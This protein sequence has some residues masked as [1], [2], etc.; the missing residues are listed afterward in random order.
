LEKLIQR[1]NVPASDHAGRVYGENQR[2]PIQLR[3]CNVLKNWVE[4]H[5]SDFTDATLQRLNQFIDSTLSRENVNLAKTLRNAISKQTDGA[6]KLQTNPSPMPE[7]K[8]PKTVFSHSLSVAEIDDEEVARQMT[9]VDYE[10][11]AAIQPIELLNCAWDKPNLKHRSPN[12]LA[13]LERQ[14]K[15]SAWVSR[16]LVEPA[17]IADRVKM[18]NMWL[19]IAARLRALNNYHGLYA[20]AQGFQHT[21]VRWLTFTRLELASAEKDIYMSLEKTF[22]FND[23]LYAEYKRKLGEV[24]SSMPCI[25]WLGLPLR[26][27][28]DLEDKHPDLIPTVAGQKLINFAK[29]KLIYN[30]IL[31]LQQHQQRQ[32]HLMGIAQIQKVV[33]SCKPND[34]KDLNALA[35]KWEPSGAQRGD[36]S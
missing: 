17:K 9:L 28:K 34:P 35:N 30:L 27:L 15:V 23:A 29:R 20:V 10:L 7:P 8:V 14:A 33:Q 22:P 12:V 3:V 18:F 6:P 25:P 1:Y 13:L 26:E 24:D 4:K 16:L 5:F 2:K 19:R 36:L 32:Y 31:D 21:A 11:F